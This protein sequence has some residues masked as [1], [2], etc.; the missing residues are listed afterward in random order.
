MRLRYQNR[1]RNV[2]FKAVTLTL[3]SR[4]HKWD[5]RT[6]PQF[7]PIDVTV[8]ARDWRLQRYV[9]TLR[10]KKPQRIKKYILYSTK[11][12]NTKWRTWGQNHIKKKIKHKWLHLFFEKKKR[13]KHLMSL[14]IFFIYRYLFL[15][16][17]E[18]HLWRDSVRMNPAKNGHKLW[19]NSKHEPKGW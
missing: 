4:Q 8:T 5:F 15:Y 13:K 14:L 11:I 1:N 19:F 17:M 18:M 10:E 3:G 12:V 2:K 16:F 6:M 7:K 9:T